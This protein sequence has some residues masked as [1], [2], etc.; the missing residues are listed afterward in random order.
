M[1]WVVEFTG[2]VVLDDLFLITGDRVGR[3]RN[4]LL[5]D[6]NVTVG[7]QLSCLLERASKTLVVDL[8]LKTSVEDV[9]R[10][11]RENVVKGRFLGDEALVV[12]GT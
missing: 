1:V 7:Y 5:T 8:C 12:E 10:I 4:L 3:N 9:L 11:E 6:A 2:W